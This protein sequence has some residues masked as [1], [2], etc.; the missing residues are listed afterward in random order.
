MGEA[1]NVGKQ[2]SGRTMRKKLVLLGVAIS[3]AA[4]LGEIAVRVADPDLLREDDRVILMSVGIVQ[5]EAGAIRYPPHRSVRSVLLSADG[6]DFDVRYPTNDLGLI[7]HRDYG[8]GS[9]DG[10][11]W[12]FVGDSFAA[13][14]E[15]GTPWIPKL[16][17]DSGLEI[18]N[19]GMGATG[20]QQ[21]AKTLL[22]ERERLSFSDIVIV[23][24]SDD[25]FRPLWAPLVEGDEL[26]ICLEDEHAAQCRER[27]PIAFLIEPDL[28]ETAILAHG[29]EVRQRAASARAVR[30]RLKQFLRSSRLLLFSKR[31]AEATAERNALRSAELIGNLAALDQIRLDFPESRIR[32]IQ[33]PDKYE[34]LRGRY[35]F[36]ASAE[37][38]QRG[39]DY[40]DALNGC[41]WSPDLYFPRDRHPNASGYVALA[42]CVAGYLEIDTAP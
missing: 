27:R 21:F 33:I 39:I 38:E 16:R 17:D 14:V 34:A 18:Y 41:E 28:S 9:V 1:T 11:A 2:M 7:D 31:L 22:S 20:I 10:R 30:S 5:D 36:D 19:L 23:A 4:L 40:F 35:D 32:F 3:V 8:S 13:G 6:I 42:Q 12:A 24:I 26:R 15:G 37:V 29:D 25:F